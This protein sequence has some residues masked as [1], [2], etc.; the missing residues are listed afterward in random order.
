MATARLKRRR[1]SMKSLEKWIKVDNKCGIFF[2]RELIAQSGGDSAE[3][4]LDARVRLE[5]H[6]DN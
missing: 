6:R 3:S 5:P 4:M 1:L 2:L